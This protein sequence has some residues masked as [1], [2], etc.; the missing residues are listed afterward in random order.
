MVSSSSALEVRCE[1]DHFCV[2]RRGPLVV[3]VWGREVEGPDLER[4][5]EVQREVVAAFGHCLVLSIVRAGLTMMVKD[6]V[7]KGG[8]NNLREFG[9]TTLGSAMVIETGGLRASFF[10]SV[11]TGIQLVARSRVPQKVFDNIDE[12]LRWLLSQPKVDVATSGAIEEILVGVYAAA[13]Q[14]G[15]PAAG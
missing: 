14:Y 5:S 11:I 12:A 10:R 1:A 8:E 6:E 13:E 7:R 3:V 15:Q 9:S 2:A 4:L